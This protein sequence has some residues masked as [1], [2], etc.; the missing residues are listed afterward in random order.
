MSASVDDLLKIVD[1]DSADAED[2]QIDFGVNLFDVGNADGLVVRFG[3][4]GKNRSESDVI[5][6]FASSSSCLL[7]AVR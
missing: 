3:W 6:A 5:G 1:V 2:R 7:E 4:S